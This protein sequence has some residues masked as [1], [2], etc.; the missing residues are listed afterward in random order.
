MSVVSA[1]FSFSRLQKFRMCP[2]AYYFR[3]EEGLE[4]PPSK[5]AEFGKAVHDVIAGVL[6]GAGSVADLAAGAVAGT[7]WLADEDVGAVVKLAGRFLDKFVPLAGGEL[8]V[9]EKFEANLNGTSLQG[10]LD[11]VEVYPQR[12]VVTDFKTDWQ[13]YGPAD[14]QQLPLYGVLASTRYP[15][16]PVSLRLWF[17]RYVREAVREVLLTD[18]MRQAASAWVRETVEGIRRA[19]ALPGWA[20]FPENPGSGCTYCGYADRCLGFVLPMGCRDA[21]EAQELAG[22]ALRLERSLEEAKRL[23]KDYV[24]AN[25]PVEVGGQFF[26]FYPK[27]SWRFADLPAFVAMLQNAGHNPWDYLR[28]SGW[29][30]RKLL[31]S[32]LGPALRAL[33]EEK[34]E[35]YFAHRDAPP[36]SESEGEIHAEG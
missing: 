16:R 7:S 9:E 23:L 11:L 17:L 24:R 10:Y 32:P 5:A 33:G 19:A 34:V 8:L 18:Q 36:S 35:Q 30:L 20:G 1:V 14:T 21:G 13:R 25:G 4:E 6:R 28:I 27:S 12:V 26:G 3:Y 2:R 22:Y 29:D 31:Y 15:G